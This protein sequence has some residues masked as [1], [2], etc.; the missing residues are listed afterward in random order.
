MANAGNLQTFLAGNADRMNLFHLLSILENIARGMQFLHNLN[1][2][3]RT[4]IH[5]DLKPSNVLLQHHGSYYTAQIA[6]F[7]PFIVCL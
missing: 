7:G 6:D 2:S 1:D 3:G 4:V 5:G